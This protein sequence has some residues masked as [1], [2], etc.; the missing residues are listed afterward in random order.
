VEKSS[1]SIPC[2]W[3]NNLELSN[4][5]IIWRQTLKSIT[6]YSWISLCNIYEGV[7]FMRY[8]GERTT[9]EGTST[10]SEWWVLSRS[11]SVTWRPLLEKWVSLSRG[12]NHL[13]RVFRTCPA[14]FHFFICCTSFPWTCMVIFVAG[15]P[16]EH[17]TGTR[18]GFNDN[19]RNFGNEERMLFG[20][21]ADIK[22]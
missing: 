14:K 21:S 13:P 17:S 10:S 9:Y 8:A 6:L 20:R 5:L 12:Q 3:L 22:R 1:P 4:N 2:S 15:F 19:S 11:C 16:T 18:L 7:F